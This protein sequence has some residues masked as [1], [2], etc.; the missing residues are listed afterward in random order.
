MFFFF[1][2]FTVLFEL[3]QYLYL[4]SLMYVLCVILLDFMLI[5]I[6]KGP[7]GK[8]PYLKIHIQN[9]EVT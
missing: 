1:N 4:C 2:V 7:Y 8:L 5:Y 3:A 9:T 6:F